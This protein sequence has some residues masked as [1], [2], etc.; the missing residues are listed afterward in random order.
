[1][2]NK[3]LARN[4]VLKKPINLFHTSGLDFNHTSFFDENERSI[5]LDVPRNPIKIAE[6][7]MVELN[8]VLRLI[9]GRVIG[10]K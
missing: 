4:E 10:E 7:L 3:K 9:L 6:I 8:R 2:H 1:M 5:A